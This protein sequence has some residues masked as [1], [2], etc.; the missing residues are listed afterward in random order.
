MIFLTSLK[1]SKPVAEIPTPSQ[2][3]FHPQRAIHQNFI[4]FLYAFLFPMGPVVISEPLF[5]ELPLRKIGEGIATPMSFMKTKRYCHASVFE[6][7][8]TALLQAL[9]F[10]SIRKS[11]HLRNCTYHF[12]VYIP[13]SSLSSLSEL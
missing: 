2:H 5:T 13:A 7:K 12:F 11:F 4:P 1:T 6:Q 10:V 3:F 8:G 9:L